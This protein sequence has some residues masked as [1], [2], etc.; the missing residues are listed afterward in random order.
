MAAPT[1]PSPPQQRMTRWSALPAARSSAP[2]LKIK[3]WLVFGALVTAAAFGVFATIAWVA[4]TPEIDS[5]ANQPQ[6]RVAAEMVARDFLD[7]RDTLLPTADRLGAGF[8]QAA[9]TDEDGEETGSAPQLNWR[10]LQWRS[11]N[12]HRVNHTD[13]SYLY[14]LH[15]FDVFIDT[16]RYE[17]SFAL[18][19]ARSEPRLVTRPTLT[20]RPAPEGGGEPLDWDRMT[21]APLPQAAA[22]RI[23]VWAQAYVADN[24][25]QLKRVTG[26]TRAGTSYRGL[27]GPWQL[28]GNPEVISVVDRGDNV[29]VRVR[30]P[31]ERANGFVLTSEYDLLVADLDADPPN[32]T[33]WGPAGTAPFLQTYGNAE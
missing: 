5:S 32:V 7:G 4:F 24:R 15:R 28:R 23:A 6:A 26:D 11:F 16:T 30:V 29:W 25:E 8:T 31:Q 20:E 14:E 18:D 22:D 13:G 3:L 21:Q 27:S 19:V 2:V 1:D 12:R 9:P 10:N 17:L 33:A